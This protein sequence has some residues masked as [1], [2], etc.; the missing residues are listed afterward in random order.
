MVGLLSLGQHA[1]QGRQHRLKQLKAS[2]ELTTNLLPL[3]SMNGA[4]VEFT[5]ELIRQLVTHP[6]GGAE[7]DDSS[8]R[9]LRPQ[10]LHQL[11]QFLMH[12][13]NLH[14]DFCSAS[15]RGQ[16]E[17]PLSINEWSKCLQ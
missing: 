16:I 14:Q 6:F 11:W 7:D 2:K 1:L 10:Y 4:G 12:T 5:A 13:Q 9:R 8:P 15:M 17:R 3:V